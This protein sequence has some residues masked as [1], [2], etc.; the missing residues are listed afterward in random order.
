MILG[1]AGP[2]CFRG[3]RQLARNILR[4]FCGIVPSLGKLPRLTGWQPVLP[5]ESLRAFFEGGGFAAEM[6]QC[7]A[8]EM[9]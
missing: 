1:S 5:R 6:R 8:G 7:F 4:T 9:E 3:C 2:E